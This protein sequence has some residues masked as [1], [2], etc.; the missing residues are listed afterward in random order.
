MPE[1]TVVGDGQRLPGA[2]QDRL[3]RARGDA[4]SEEFTDELD[5]VTVRDAVPNRE[6]GDRRLQARAEG[7]GRDLGRQLCP[8]GAA[9]VG[10]AQ[11]L[12]PV[13]AKDLSL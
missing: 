5:R 8:R 12:E 13:L 2:L 11:A 1:Q 9:A 10:A 3:D 7:A 4:R 6:G